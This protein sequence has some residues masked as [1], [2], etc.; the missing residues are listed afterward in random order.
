MRP[1]LLD[2]AAAGEEE[3]E[4]VDRH[5]GEV[6]A[7]G[8]EP[9]QSAAGGADRG[10][11]VRGHGPELAADLVHGLAHE[12]MGQLAA[13]QFDPLWVVLLDIAA[14]VVPERR[15]V[16]DEI[17]DL[18][19]DGRHRE[20]ECARRGKDEHAV[21]QDHGGRAV[22]VQPRLE[23]GDHRAQDQGEHGRG[24]QRPEHAGEIADELAQEPERAENGGQGGS[25]RKQDQG[26][27]QRA[28][29]R[30]GEKR[31]WRVLGHGATFA[32]AR[33]QAK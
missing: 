3:E 10:Q 30:G 18:V 24:G 22:E 29:L 19:G 23:H 20:D 11:R 25:A 17:E 5:D 7:E 21:E 26:A 27:A 8:E 14:A 15:G 13:E 2:G 31:A 12:R 6:R 9:Q 16:A 28:P 33:T 1:D 4:Q 32:Q